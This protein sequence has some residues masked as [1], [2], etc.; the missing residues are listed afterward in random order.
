MPGKSSWLVG[1]AQRGEQVENLDMDHSIR[2]GVGPVDLVHHHDQVQ[3]AG[4]RL[5]DHELGLRQQQLGGI[6]QHDGAVHH[7][8]DA[9]YLAA[10]IGVAGGVYDVDSNAVPGH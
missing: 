1:G 3:A 6:H 4:Q 8:Q 9:F 10:E 2:P 5:A 7:I